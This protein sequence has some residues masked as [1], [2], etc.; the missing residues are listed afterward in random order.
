VRLAVRTP[1]QDTR[2]RR[3]NTARP[4]AKRAIETASKAKTATA[5]ISSAGA[6]WWVNG[7]KSCANWDRRRLFFAVYKPLP[8]LVTVPMR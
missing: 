7:E 5:L 1:S 8:G 4:A 6:F 3:P 2:S